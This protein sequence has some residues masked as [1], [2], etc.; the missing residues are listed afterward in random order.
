MEIDL[1]KNYPKS[2]R[3]LDKR[4]S[5]KSPEIV[6]IARHLGK[7]F[8][9]ETENLVTVDSDMIQNIGQMLLRTVEYYNI[10]PDAR[11]LDVGCA[12]GYMLYDLKDNILD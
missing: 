9:M 5:E 6:K 10:K 8:L 7:E 11:I 2:N 1:L 3:N 4:L 12:K